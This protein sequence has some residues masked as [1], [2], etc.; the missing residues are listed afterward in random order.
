MPS[1]NH[2]GSITSTTITGNANNVLLWISSGDK[3]SGCFKVSAGNEG[4]GNGVSGA[5]RGSLSFNHSHTHTISTSNKGSG[6]TFSVIQ[7]F[8]VCYIWKRVS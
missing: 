1:H 4:Y 3:A 5:N 2:T 8:I 7:P 6:K